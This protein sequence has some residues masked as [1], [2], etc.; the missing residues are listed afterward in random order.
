[1]GELWDRTRLI[2]EGKELSA[3]LARQAFNQIPGV[4][5]VAALIV[6]WW[7][8][9]TF[10]TSPFRA[11]LARWG[12]VKGGRHI[13]SGGTYRFLSIV[14]PI[15]VAAVTAYAVSRIMK[16]VREQQMRK[17]MIRI[18]QLGEEIQALVNDRLAILEKAKEAGLLS[19]GEYLMKKANLCTEYARIPS[20]QITDLLI[21]KLTS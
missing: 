1:V 11:F 8:A 9:S 13:I 15:L 18:S 19:D 21:V 14:L 2:K 10:T 12:L 7:V 5:A 3:F 20:S 6:G 4:S 16:V 17:N